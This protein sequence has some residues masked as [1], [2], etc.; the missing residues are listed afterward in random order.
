MQLNN[1]ELDC[2]S[3]YRNVKFKQRKR[4]QNK[5]I[6]GSV[7]FLHAELHRMA[8]L[9]GKDSANYPTEWNN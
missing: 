8:E 3:V 4:K 7:H 5:S 6:N 9:M 1:F 2:G